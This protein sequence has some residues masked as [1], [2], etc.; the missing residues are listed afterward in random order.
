MP[1]RILLVEDDNRLSTLIAGYLRKHEYVVDTVLNGDDAVD[2]ILTG[3]P[4]LV[5]LDVNLP[6]KDGFEICREAREHYDGVII[7]VTARDEPFDELLGLEFGA[8]DY[9]H[10]PVEPRILLARIKA[11]L[12]RAPVRQA[13]GA[14]GQPESHTF[15]KFTIDRTNRTVNL[16][17]GTTPE[18]TSAEFD[19]L[20]VLACHAGEVV[21]RDD[22]MLQ[23]RGVEFDGLDRTIDGRISKLR[24]KLRDD[25][26]SP[27]RIKTIRS[28]GYQFSKN[29][30]E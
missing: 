26:S 17:D 11:Q 7:M 2:A 14:G 25:A 27:Q 12:R 22:L 19:L 21:S 10:K 28:K 16:P 3:R 24:R 1:F 23:L 4:D 9:V 6:G 15:G 13:D 20:W 30:W 5:I 18:L 8:D 29:A